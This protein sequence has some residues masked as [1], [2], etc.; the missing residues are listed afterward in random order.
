M[1][2]Y[3]DGSIKY[4]DEE[5]LKRIIILLLIPAA[6]ASQG[7]NLMIKETRISSSSHHELM[8]QKFGLLQHRNKQQFT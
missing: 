7:F 3:D 2:Y 8:T 4:D 5:K 6:L 1:S